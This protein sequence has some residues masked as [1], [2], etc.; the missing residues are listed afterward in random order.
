MER[1]QTMT[2]RRGLQSAL[3]V[4]LPALVAPSNC[5]LTD[6][7]ASS[8]RQPGA[9]PP[10]AN[11]TP[12]SLAT[13]PEALNPCSFPAYYESRHFGPFAAPEEL[14]KSMSDTTYVGDRPRYSGSWA[15]K[16]SLAPRPGIPTGG[17][18]LFEIRARDALAFE[19]GAAEMTRTGRNMLDLIGAKTADGARHGIDGWDYLGA[20]PHEMTGRVGHL[21]FHVDWGGIAIPLDTLEQALVAL[22][23]GIPDLPVA[24]LDFPSDATHED[25]CSLVTRQEAEAIL[26]KLVTRPFQ[27]LDLYP[28]AV[29]SGTGCSYYTKNHHVLSIRPWWRNGKMVFNV[30][31]LVGKVGTGILTPYAGE[32]DR[33][34]ANAIDAL[35]VLK[36]DKLLAVSWR[37]SST[38]QAGAAKI[39]SIAMKRLVGE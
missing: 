6:R 9:H 15:C 37:M 12:D 2:M 10:A 33:V 34:G 25:P 16:L 26:G 14:V 38:D 3:V 27:S 4:L 21:A 19:T 29:K 8:S 18:V 23:D 35:Y 31:S 5:G 28:L 13:L 22:R 11:A 32:W 20:Y 39:A 7:T 30:S 36:G 1:E 17:I 24:A